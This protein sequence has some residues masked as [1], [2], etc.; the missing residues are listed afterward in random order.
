MEFN[1]FEDDVL[2]RLN[3]EAST[4]EPDIPG[5][6]NRI[7]D[8]RLEREIGSGGAGVVY[9]AVQENLGRKVALKVIPLLTADLSGSSRQ[10]REREARI[11]A[12]LN[13]PNVVEVFDTG[14]TPGFRWVAM[15][16]IE[17]WSL[18]EILQGKADDL[19][20]PGSDAWPAFIVP[21]LYQIA[22]AL[23]A[24]HL[25]GIIHR[26]IKPANVLVSRN[27]IAYLV[28][29]GL[30]RPERSEDP[31]L[32]EGFCGT[33]RYASPEQARQRKLT[34]ESDVFSF[35]SLAFEALD[36]KPAFAG[37]TTEEVLRAIRFQDP[38]WANSKS[39]PADLRAIIE[40]CL[41]KD[42]T[43]SYRNGNEVAEELSRVI[44][45]R[46]V[47]ART[48]GV[49]S[50]AIQRVRRRPGRALAQAASLA[51]MAIT[52]LAAFQA[53]RGNEKN[54]L[55]Q[56][57]QQYESALKLFH[58]GEWEALKPLLVSIE[59]GE[60]EFPQ[61]I[62]LAADTQ[63]R[64][65]EY[66]SARKLYQNKINKQTANATDLVGLEIARAA[67]ADSSMPY[68]ESLPKVQAARDGFIQGLYFQDRKEFE[69]SQVALQL[70]L[71]QEPLSFPIL[72]ALASSA[73]AQ[74]MHQQTI[75][76]LKSAIAAKPRAY[77]QA[78]TLLTT[79]RILNRFDEAKRLAQQLIK[80]FPDRPDPIAELAHLLILDHR[81]EEAKPLARKAFQMDVEHKVPWVTN[82][83]SFVFE[84]SGEIEEAENILRIGL[85]S[86]PNSPVLLFRQAWLA[87]K[88]GNLA[89]AESLSVTLQKEGS[90]YWRNLGLSILG[91]IYKKRDEN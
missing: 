27:G 29:F 43:A 81:L 85:E 71:D 80:S 64:L 63:I 59:D 84:I 82:V 1:S 73:S 67:L 4:E 36:G 9:E 56:N 87:Y 31:T 70:A 90:P 58:A 57:Q 72:V 88:R 33:P 54:L 44:Q 41:E 65:G 12:Q 74:G 5:V 79:L 50:R 69:L 89:K 2:R 25:Q 55:L 34:P 40:K 62:S 60:S 86:T 66:Q 11:L 8:F 76:H 13:H 17:G 6:G 18:A 22:D 77:E 3:F 14:S 10:R 78:A 28:D 23:G 46:P 19:P 49:V 48:R 53:V 24:A 32:T 39:I 38:H 35:G 61:L 37:E 15:E 83:Y 20:K 42:T 21:L 75:D 68:L 47:H 16:L 45:F 52:I 51:L 30:A 91:T 7:G 26:D